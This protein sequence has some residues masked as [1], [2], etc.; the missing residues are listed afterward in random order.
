MNLQTRFSFLVSGFWLL[1]PAACRLLPSAC[2]L[3]PASCRLLPA[4]CRLPPASCRRPPAPC[5]LPPAS[6]RLAVL[7]PSSLRKRRRFNAGFRQCPIQLLAPV[8]HVTARS[9]AIDHSQRNRADIRQL[10]EHAP[11]NVHSLTGSER[12]LL[13]AQAQLALALQNQVDFFLILV[14]PRHLSAVRFQQ[15][16]RA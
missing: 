11:W 10:M 3:P 8:S 7:R 14:V 2:R 16:G 13:I 4:S 15:I 12:H 1:P 9:I 6:C 5:F